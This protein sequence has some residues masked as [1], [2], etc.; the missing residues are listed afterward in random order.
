MPQFRWTPYHTNLRN[1]LA[2]YFRSQADSDAL[3]LEAGLDPVDFEANPKA[4]TRWTFLITEA[5]TRRKLPALIDAALARYP[6]DEYL[7][8]AKR[9]DLTAVNGP[10]I[11]TEVQWKGPADSGRLEA[12]IGKVSTLLDV[13]FLERGTRVA[14]AVVR[15]RWP[16]SSG[17][18]GSG[19]G[20]VV[21]GARGPLIVTNNH[22]LDGRERAGAAQVQ[23]NYQLTAE[24][25]NAAITEKA[26][27]P[28]GD[29]NFA[30]SKEHDWSAVRIDDLPP[31]V[32]P[33]SLTPQA[34]KEGDPVNII[35]H[36][37]GGPKK[38][39]LYHNV[40][41]FADDN[42]VQYLTDTEPGSSGAPG[43]NNEWQVIALHNSGGISAEPGAKGPALR[44]Q[45]IHINA[46][47]RG[48]QAAGM[49]E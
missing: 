3:L 11:E 13:A 5:E 25:R 7:L 18:E 49:V 2:H 31:G 43:F 15:I 34:P 42:I 27:A 20:F 6:D 24:R 35:Q 33:L 16:D 39:A 47:I 23:F 44:N 8:G 37:G 12:I 32:T 9:G 21:Q 17:A 48:L 19:T 30:T 29:G 28:E 26:L 41:V 40:I 36:P 46:V 1:I 10:D 4:I 22:V 38:I 14:N 45:G